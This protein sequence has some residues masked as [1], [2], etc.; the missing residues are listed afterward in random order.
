[1]LAGTCSKGWSV[2]QRLHEEI[3]TAKHEDEQ[4]ENEQ[5]SDF[6]SGHQVCEASF[7]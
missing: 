6:Y 2:R 4:Q 5:P 3:Q 1:M 7:V